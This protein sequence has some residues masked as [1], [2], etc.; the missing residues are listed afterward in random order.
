MQDRAGTIDIIVKLA[1]KAL[2]KIVERRELQDPATG[3]KYS[4]FG[5]P[6]HLNPSTLV[7]CEPY[8]VF[9]TPD[10]TTG[11]NRF[12]S[13]D[14]AAAW[15]AEKEDRDAAAFRL[16]LEGMDDKRVADQLLYW[17]GGFGGRDQRGN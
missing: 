17:Q 15:F 5:V 11:G 6:G 3:R 12:P 9:Q 13:R 7:S 14:A 2:P 8:Y 10:G 16:A 4:L 1:R